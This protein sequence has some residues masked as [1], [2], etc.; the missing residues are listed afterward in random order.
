MHYQVMNIDWILNQH[1]DNLDYSFDLKNCEPHDGICAHRISIVLHSGTILERVLAKNILCAGWDIVKIIIKCQ[2]DI[3]YEDFLHFVP[4]FNPWDKDNFYRANKLFS[5]ECKKHQMLNEQNHNHNYNL[6]PASNP[7]NYSRFVQLSRQEHLT[8]LGGLKLIVPCHC[9]DIC[10]GAYYDR[11]IHRERI[12]V[13]DLLRD[14]DPGLYFITKIRFE[15]RN[16]IYY[17]YRVVLTRPENNNQLKQWFGQI[18][19]ENSGYEFSQP[20]LIR[21]YEFELELDIRDKNIHTLNIYFDITLIPERRLDDYAW[22]D[23]SWIQLDWFNRHLRIPN[24]EIISRCFTEIRILIPE[25]VSI[26]TITV[27]FKEF[28]DTIISSVPSVLRE[29]S[30][31]ILTAQSAG[32]NKMAPI[33]WDISSYRYFLDLGRLSSDIESEIKIYGKCLIG[34]ESKF[35]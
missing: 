30:F 3:S 35:S 20:F 6:I 14:N 5:S 27:Q 24:G 10:W 23:H 9:Q 26:K 19:E 13:W 31:I 28:D 25:G 21:P 22:L 7:S 17:P 16:K 4:C 34:V 29:D 12:N 11:T 1:S 32:T 8:A 2:Y 15:T 33:G 18:A